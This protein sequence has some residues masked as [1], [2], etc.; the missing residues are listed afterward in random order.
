[1][2]RLVARYGSAAKGNTR[3]TH[4]VVA[5]AATV[6]RVQ[7]YLRPL[8]I[9]RVANVTGLDRVGIPTV[10]VCRPNARS[11]AVSQGKGLTLEAARASGLMESIESWH[12]ERV[13]L[14]LLL[15]SW[16]ELRA[17]RPIVDVARLPRLSVSRFHAQR[18]ILWVEGLE[19]FTGAP[20]WVPYDMVHTDFTLPLPTGS[21]CF[22]MSSN[23][24]ASGNHR[25]E[26]ISHGIAEV[27][28]RDAS[29]L[30]HLRGG[31]RDESTRVDL[32]S[33]DDGACREALDRF[34][35]A[36]LAVGVWETTS[37]VG[38]ACF[39]VYVADR[40]PS[41]LRHLYAT[42][43]MGC[44]P[45]REIALLRALTEAAQ[46]RLTFIS[47][48]RDDTDRETYERVRNPDLTASIVPR[49]TS[50]ARSFRAAPSFS[51][52]RFE[53]DVAWQLER[54]AAAGIDEV[55]VVDLTKPGL[56]IPVVRVIV[57]GLESMHDAPGYVPGARA[58]TILRGAEA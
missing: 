43:G 57:P 40:E 32:D 10:V 45:A 5:P 31:I 42:P 24:L 14:P 7:R 22:V 15:S 39:L 25:L 29:T 16:H 20:A 12:A 30:W 8:G 34:E 47:G 50:G 18:A 9:T 51:G 36:G 11:L 56:D 21:G 6:E 26:A 17:S 54:L 53:D 19:L 49:L 46:A 33:V 35:A 37:D 58:T 23:G 41:P 27:V 13:G 1:M 52:D 28:E 55:V 44:H 48:S 4:R 3:G 2:D 38:I